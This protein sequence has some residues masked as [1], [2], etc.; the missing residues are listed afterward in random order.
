[1]WRPILVGA[2]HHGASQRSRQ[3]R[4]NLSA[5][6]CQVLQLLMPLLP[7]MLTAP[8]KPLDLL[9][10]VVASRWEGPF[11]TMCQGGGRKIARADVFGVVF[12]GCLG[13]WYS[14]LQHPHTSQDEAHAKMR[15]WL[16]DAKE[17]RVPMPWRRKRC[18][19]SKLPL[20]G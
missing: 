19:Q 20:S 14:E 4:R 18:R 6:T 12:N 1:M 3:R 15:S 9:P 11:L 13:L 7:R 5:T 10:L 16:G 2:P 17:R 8:P